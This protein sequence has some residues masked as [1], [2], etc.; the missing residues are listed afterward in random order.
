MAYNLNNANIL[1]Y[2][3]LGQNF[4]DYSSGAATNNSTVGG[5]FV[6]SN[7][8]SINGFSSGYSPGWGSGGTNKSYLTMTSQS[9]IPSNG[10]TVS[11]WV[12]C[13]V[14]PTSQNYS[15]FFNWLDL[16][17]GLG[18]SYYNFSL[19][20]N[21]ST[22]TVSIYGNTNGQNTATSYVINDTNWHHY[23]FT[24]SSNGTVNV[25]VDNVNKSSFS[26]TLTGQPLYTCEIARSYYGESGI[27]AYFNEYIAFN[28]TLTATEISYL[29]LYPG[30][31]KIS[32]APS[33]LA[34]YPCFLE[35]SKIL[36]LDPIGGQE[37]YVPVEHLKQGDLIQTSHS[38][39]KAIVIIGRKTIENSPESDIKN[40]L[41]RIKKQEQMTEDLVLTGEH[42]TLHTHLSEEK[43]AAVEKYMGRIYITESAYY[44]VPAHLDERFEPYPN[45]GPA[46]IWHFALE[47]DNPFANYGVFANGLLVESSSIRYMHDLSNMEFV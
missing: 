24:Y 3:P 7:T 16:R 19:N 33:G 1:Q 42:C 45:E 11:M 25:Y 37:S 6:L 8:T 5:S 34:G 46:T 12:K 47:H 22:L 13:K 39:H 27:D 29:Y 9:P 26:Y 17:T 2:Y 32:S 18:T 4:Y 38:G 40:R 43:L 14:I 36:R 44:R 20:V 21:G 15:R 23:C 10:I 28:R 30:N 35:G 31:L 41:Y